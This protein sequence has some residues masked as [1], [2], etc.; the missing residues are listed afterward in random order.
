MI[1]YIIYDIIYD[2]IYYKFIT[3]IYLVWFLYITLYITIRF[4]DNCI[5][6]IS[7]N[8]KNVISFYLTFNF[9][10]Y[11]FIKVLYFFKNIKLIFLPFLIKKKI[12]FI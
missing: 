8:K 9:Y 11:V 7:N 5:R 4:S 3:D 12:Y 2:N 6:Q 10:I 1:L